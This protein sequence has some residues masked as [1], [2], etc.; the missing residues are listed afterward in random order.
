MREMW[1]TYAGQICQGNGEEV[2]SGLFPMSGTVLL[3]AK[4]ITGMQYYSR[5]EVLPCH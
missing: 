4:L 1:A 2:S 3:I 5:L